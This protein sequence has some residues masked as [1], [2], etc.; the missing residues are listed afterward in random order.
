MNNRNVLPDIDSFSDENN[1]TLA[2]SKS[3][4]FIQFYSTRESLM[5]VDDYRSFVKNCRNRV[6]KSVAYTHYKAFL[7]GLGLDHCQVNGY[8]NSDMATLEMHHAIL[9]LFDICFIVT[10]YFLNKYNRVTTFDVVQAVKDE[11]K[12]NHIALTMMSKTSHQ[13]YH[14]DDGLFIHP[15]MCVGHWISFIK[16]YKEGLTQDICFKLLKYIRNSNEYGESKD[17]KNLLALRDEIKDWS[18]YNVE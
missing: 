14:N 11:H 6:R 10:E 1:P 9:T 12:L 13:I 18:E 4:Y 5:D 16:K 15:N 17:N 2:S 7:M 8:I 3:T